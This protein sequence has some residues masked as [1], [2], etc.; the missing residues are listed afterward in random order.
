M[1]NE[2][3]QALQNRNLMDYLYHEL[4]MST[5][6]IAK[7][8]GCSHVTVRDRLI[9]LGI[10]LRPSRREVLTPDLTPSPELVHLVFALKGD[11]SAGIYNGEGQIHFSSIDKVLVESVRD[12]LVKI[13]LHPKKTGPHINRGYSKNAKPI[14]RLRAYSKLFVQHYLSL[15]PQ[16]LLELG[17]THPWDALRGFLETE[18]SVGYNG[19][20]LYVVL[21]SN[22]DL[23]LTHV[24]RDLASK[25]G[26]ETSIVKGGITRSKN[27]KP[28]YQLNLL[29]T[30]PE[31]EEFLNKLNPC[32]K[33][34]IKIKV[35]E[36]CALCMN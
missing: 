21:I 7:L 34:P 23:D 9:R 1:N 20:S 35:K 36:E 14:Y 27:A 10:E 33:W 28:Y 32:V 17:L 19:N 24:A 5:I 12:D 22:T 6:Q 13:G 3:K 11:G 26:Y 16:G 4:G 31:K 18:G 15:T 25:L 29:G 8:Y 30:T 2:A